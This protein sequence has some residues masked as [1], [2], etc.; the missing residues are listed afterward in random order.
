M[1]ISINDIR[2]HNCLWFTQKLKSLN[3][4]MYL[5]YF[6]FN[7]NFIVLTQIFQQKVIKK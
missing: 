7:N 5:I 6:N 4:I 2:L 3:E 1:K